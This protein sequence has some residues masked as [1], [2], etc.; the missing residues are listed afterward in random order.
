M[1]TQITDCNAAFFDVNNNFFGCIPGINEVLARQGLLQGNWCLDEK[2]ILGEG[3]M[4]EI[5]RVYKSYPEL[6][7]D[8]FVADN[9]EKWKEKVRTK[10]EEIG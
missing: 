9:I 6:N 8:K 10:Q 3:Q 4:E 1:G 2:E 5:D 7:D